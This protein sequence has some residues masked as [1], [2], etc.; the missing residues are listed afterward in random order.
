MTRYS[1]VAG[2]LLVD[3]DNASQHVGE[4]HKIDGEAELVL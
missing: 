2:P 3:S 1:A 4:I